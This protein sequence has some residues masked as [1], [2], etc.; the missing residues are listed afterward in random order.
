MP[1]IDAKITKLVREHHLQSLTLDVFDTVLLYRYWPDKQHAIAVAKKWQKSLPELL[2][3]ELSALELIEWR[4]LAQ[5]ELK[6]LQS[7]TASQPA[8][9]DYET[10]F[11]QILDFI[12]ERYGLEIDDA[13]LTLARQTMLRD[14][15]QAT[16]ELLK[17]NLAL[18]HAITTL[19]Q[20]LPDL[21]VYF[22]SH[23][24]YS[25]D[26]IQYFLDYFKV[27]IFDGGTSAVSCQATKSSGEL[28]RKI[29]AEHLLSSDFQLKTNLHIGDSR[30]EDYL[31][32]RQN[33]GFALHYRPIR[34]R[35]LRTLAGSLDATIKLQPPVDLFGDRRSAELSRLGFLA[36]NSPAQTF[37]LASSQADELKFQ[38]ITL[39]PKSFASENLL[40]APSLNP[41]NLTSALIWLLISRADSRWNLRAIFSLILALEARPKASLLEKRQTI[42]RFCFG[43]DCP[44]SD[45]ILQNRSDQEFLEA[46]LQDFATADPHYTEHLRE[47]YASC[48]NYLPRHDQPLTIVDHDPTQATMRLFREF[49]K[50]HGLGNPISGFTISK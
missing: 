46:F 15:L 5:H 37:L 11:N 12:I 31:P 36:K 41:Q 30:A 38:G 34:A 28:Y 24:P 2:G 33:G 22:L 26:Q 16:A 43:P 17:P 45:L 25:R 21:K 48:A 42:Y 20:A 18:I 1:H 50:L 27:E 6:F 44:T 29:E 32:V 7:Q 3:L 9:L 14:Q 39:L 8:I 40:T 19:K 35:S 47:A 49:A 10:W 23:E 13:K 4:N